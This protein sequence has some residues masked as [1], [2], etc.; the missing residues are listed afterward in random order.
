MQLGT[1][2]A[3]FGA[4]FYR[5]LEKIAVDS[6]REQPFFARSALFFAKC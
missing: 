4:E 3:P 6:V 5:R 1:K 2:T